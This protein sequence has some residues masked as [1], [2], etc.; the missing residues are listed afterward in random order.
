[1][2][3]CHKLVQGR[4]AQNGIEGEADLRDVEQDTFRAEVLKRPECDREGD[5][6]ARN[7]RYQAHPRE[8]ARRLELRHQYLQ[9]FETCQANQIQR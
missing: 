8:W 6:S 9:L 3:N 4:P 1:M 2:G 5:T 7:D